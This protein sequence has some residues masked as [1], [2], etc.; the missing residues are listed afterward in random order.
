M[1]WYDEV[2][3]SKLCYACQKPFLH[4]ESVGPN[5]SI[6]GRRFFLHQRCAELPRE[7]P[8]H[9]LHPN[10]KLTLLAESPYRR[11]DELHCC[12][13]CRKA[14][15]KFTY[16]CS[17]CEFDLHFS[18]AFI[19]TKL[20]HP[21]HPEH[22][23][24][25]LQRPSIFSCDACW[26]RGDEQ[27]SYICVDC[28]VWIH[29]SCAFLPTTNYRKD[30]DHPLSLVY[31]VP[32]EFRRF[33]IP[34][35]YCLRDIPS[36][37]WVY[38]CGPCRYIIHL[39]CFEKYR[40][41]SDF[42]G[43]IESHL[44]K[45]MSRDNLVKFPTND[46]AEVFNHVLRKEFGMEIVAVPERVKL[47]R[48]EHSIDSLDLQN[49]SNSKN[50]EITCDVCTKA[51][52]FSSGKCEEC[53]Y[54]FHF[55]C[56]QLPGELPV[57]YQ[58][59]S[60]EFTLSFLEDVRDKFTCYACKLDS[61][62]YYF[63]AEKNY[64]DVTCALLPS[65]LIHK[66][67]EHPLERTVG[68]ETTHQKCRSCGDCFSFVFGY[69]CFDCDFSLDYACITLPEI[70][71]HRWDKHPLLLSFPPFSDRPGDF[72]C[73]I[74][75]E[76]IHPKRWHYHCKECNQSF[77]P[78][79][80][81]RVLYRNFTFGGIFEFGSHPHPLKLA[82]E[83]GY[84]S[85]CDSCHEPMYCKRVFQCATCWFCICFSCATKVSK[86]KTKVMFDEDIPPFNF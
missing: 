58:W 59:S 26:E 68:L 61:N 52:L 39:G 60:Q 33:G 24:T 10:H 72:Y 75:E 8:E 69:A 51:I 18:C 11:D 53:N 22:P 57:L 48:C 64:L 81:P 42:G 65:R 70:V 56:A 78:L 5:F 43:S 20:N 83:G 14:L 29:E 76:E 32:N 77:H 66:A 27:E 40:N 19:D 9:P 84:H 2:P 35:D 45:V 47:R 82:R 85:R 31:S 80:I 3:W 67:H 1:E 50:N 79:C 15:V 6:E 13:R 44:A 25:L 73:E 12:H 46:S 30:H 36:R 23:L 17:L 34:C 21:C 54:F 16:H 7:I 37:S 41:P 55:T 63:V 86:F 38:Y 49:V 71:N 28:Q 62:G 4:Q 74:C